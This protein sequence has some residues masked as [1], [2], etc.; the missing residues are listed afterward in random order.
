MELT[1][2]LGSERAHRFDQADAGQPSP[3]PGRVGHRKGQKRLSGCATGSIAGEQRGRRD[4]RR[5][6]ASA[7]HGEE[8]ELQFEGTEAALVQRLDFSPS[9]IECFA[10]I[11]NGVAVRMPHQVSEVLAIRIRWSPEPERHGV[12]HIRRKRLL[13]PTKLGKVGGQPR[14]M[15]RLSRRIAPRSALRCGRRSRTCCSS[16]IARGVPWRDGARTQ[17][18]SPHRAGRG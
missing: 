3:L 5:W 6:G 18:R 17:D 16:R 4:R 9:I 2:A 11:V 15:G 13:T 14:S 10:R 1:L 7:R 12:E 8:R